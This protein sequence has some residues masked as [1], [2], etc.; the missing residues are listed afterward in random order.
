MDNLGRFK[1]NFKNIEFD[2]FGI[3]VRDIDGCLNSLT[4]FFSLKNV[5]KIF[6]DEKQNVKVLFFNISDIKFELVQPNDPNMKSPVDNLLKRN[7][8]FYHICFTTPNIEETIKQMK[9][10]GIVVE[11]TNLMNAVAFENR[12]IEF[13]FIKQ[14]GLIELIE[15]S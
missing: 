4:S 8:S 13:L 2:H 15:K 5:S 6:T 3:A 11:V 7:I 12:K 10:K 1:M 14:F 9:K